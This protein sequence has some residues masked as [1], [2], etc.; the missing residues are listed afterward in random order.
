MVTTRTASTQLPHSLEPTLLTS[1]HTP[2]PTPPPK[3][4]SLH[5]VYCICSQSPCCISSFPPAAPSSFP[6][7]GPPSPK[8]CCCC[9]YACC[10]P[11][12]PPP[13]TANLP[14]SS[15]KLPLS[16]CCSSFCYTKLG[17]SGTRCWSCCTCCRDKRC[18]LGSPM[19]VSLLA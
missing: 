7:P 15:M 2:A 10:V 16:F 18:K 19:L 3:Y 1:L 12:S 6:T 9:C 13:S 14:P 11:S 17:R 5:H 8:I 4:S